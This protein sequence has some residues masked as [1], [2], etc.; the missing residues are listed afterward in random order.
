MTLEW[1]AKNS[2]PGETVLAG[3]KSTECDLHQSLLGGQT[4]VPGFGA[5]DCPC[6]AHL[7]YFKRM[8]RIAL[9]TWRRFVGQEGFAVGGP[10]RGNLRE[11]VASDD[12]DFTRENA[13][14]PRMLMEAFSTAWASAR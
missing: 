9:M 11:A 4:V 2:L 1:S 12:R 8:P 3:T 6:E 5:T 14:V 13:P 10:D 7:A